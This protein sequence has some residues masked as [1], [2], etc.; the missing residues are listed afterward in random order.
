[1]RLLLSRGGHALSLEIIFQ[2]SMIVETQIAH[3]L[4]LLKAA[5]MG[6]AERKVKQKIGNDPRNLTWSQGKF[7]VPGRQD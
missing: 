5:I 7:R 1:V 3:Q 6:L 4:C 2:S